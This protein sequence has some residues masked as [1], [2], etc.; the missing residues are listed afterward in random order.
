MTSTYTW[1]LSAVV[2]DQGE[3]IE[4]CLLCGREALALRSSYQMHL[5]RG[6]LDVSMDFMASE[7]MWGEGISHP[8]HI[9]SQRFYRILLENKLTGGLRIDPIV[10]HG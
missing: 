10:L 4:L 6:Q 1:G 5:F 7:P 9:I 3:K 8:V 2:R